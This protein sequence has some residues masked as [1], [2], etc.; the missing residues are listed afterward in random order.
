[1][2]YTWTLFHAHGNIILSLKTPQTD[3]YSEKSWFYLQKLKDAKEKAAY[4]TVKLTLY[5]CIIIQSL[6]ERSHA[7]ETS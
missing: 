4:S 1:M 5:M 6:G 3:L 7:Q 2:R